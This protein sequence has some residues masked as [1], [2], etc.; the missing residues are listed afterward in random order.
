[1]SMAV[2]APSP[3]RSSETAVRDTGT[4]S[5]PH[6]GERWNKSHRNSIEGALL[7]K[8]NV[9]RFLQH[10][11]TKLNLGS[12][13]H[14]A[15]SAQPG[16]DDQSFSEAHTVHHHR[17]P[18]PPKRHHNHHHHG[19]RHPQL[20][21]HVLDDAPS[22]QQQQQSDAAPSTVAA[23]AP[24][25]CSLEPF[26]VKAGI[27]ELAFTTLLSDLSNIAYNVDDP[28]WRRASPGGGIEAEEEE[29]QQGTSPLVNW[30]VA[31]QLSFVSCSETRAHGPLP[32]PERAATRR[33]ATA[34]ATAAAASPPPAATAAAAL[35][36][37]AA[38]IPV[39]SE[40]DSQ[41]FAMTETAKQLLTLSVVPESG[42]CGEIVSAAE[43][44]T[45]SPARSPR[46]SSPRL[47]RPDVE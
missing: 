36:A 25:R 29:A 14:S 17:P 31:N 9:H 38:S 10:I 30:L 8:R 5:A 16:S 12:H 21:Q 37:A 27:S 23:A 3:G 44:L 18:H 41:E 4:Q 24:S 34:A 42:A 20:Q 39:C 46:G 43:A 28:A 19:L 15:T 13:G 6:S 40:A 2:R 47:F 33:T 32:L 35:K 22:N 26:L 11:T 45:G 1:M 7:L